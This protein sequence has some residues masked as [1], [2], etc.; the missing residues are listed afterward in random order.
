MLEFFQAKTQISKG[1]GQKQV[2]IKE[3]AFQFVVNS[4]VEKIIWNN[5]E[6]LRQLGKNPDIGDCIQLFDEQMVFIVLE[7]MEYDG[8]V[9]LLFQVGQVAIIMNS[10]A[11]FAVYMVMIMH[12][13]IVLVLKS[14]LS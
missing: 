3:S 12:L 5:E 8:K 2:V 1:I 4:R 6:L 14:F 10:A 7:V 13:I 9:V 11:I